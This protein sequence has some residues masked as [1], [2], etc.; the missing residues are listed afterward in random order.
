MH[1]STTALNLCGTVTLD[2]REPR[3]LLCLCLLLLQLLCRRSLA[4]A[5][6]PSNA[7]GRSKA[8]APLRLLLPQLQLVNKLGGEK[9]E[10]VK[11]SR[12]SL[13]PPPVTA[14]LFFPKGFLRLYLWLLLGI[15]KAP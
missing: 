10:G 1:W 3:S 4:P 5:P 13:A 8:G 6:A 2:S 15:L 14:S 9:G 11:K 12:R 7:V